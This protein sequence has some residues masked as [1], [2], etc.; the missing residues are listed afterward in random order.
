MVINMGRSILAVVLGVIL[1]N[2]VIVAV[3]MIILLLY[4]PPPGFDM[5]DPEAMRQ[6]ILTMPVGAFLMVSL[7][8][9]LGTAA[10]ATLAAWMPRRSTVVPAVI[11]GA[12]ILAAGVANQMMQ[13]H[14]AW[15]WPVDL[16]TYP[17]GTWAGLMI[18]RRR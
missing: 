11:V 15:F 7:A 9:F 17:L 12:L 2:V 16:A 18:G 14:P 3:E 8:H 4:P 5:H 13:S 6:L 10:G 1:A